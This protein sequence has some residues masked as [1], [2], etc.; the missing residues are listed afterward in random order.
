VQHVAE[1]LS[2][3]GLIDLLGTDL[4]HERHL[5]HL[6]ELEYTAALARVMEEKGV[7]NPDL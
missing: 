7:L 3:K 1:L 5:Q 6:R 4:H 2:K